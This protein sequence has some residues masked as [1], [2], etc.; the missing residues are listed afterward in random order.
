MNWNTTAQA[1]RFLS[2]GEWQAQRLR[3]SREN[4]K[5]RKR[6]PGGGPRA[7]SAVRPSPNGAQREGQGGAPGGRW[8]GRVVDGPGRSDRSIY[9][10]GGG[11]T[12]A[13]VAKMHGTPLVLRDFCHKILP[14]APCFCFLC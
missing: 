12:D 7:L 10:V 14:V 9:V 6:G 2:H 11:C 8:V 3:A 13:L 1:V 5:N 4:K